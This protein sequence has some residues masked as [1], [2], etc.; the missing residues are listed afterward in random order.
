MGSK[1]DHLSDQ[2]TAE[3]KRAVWALVNR[4]KT[5][6]SKY[7]ALG[8]T[9]GHC[10]YCH[11][12]KV[13]LPMPKPLSLR[14]HYTDELKWSILNPIFELSENH[15]SMDAGERFP[16]KSTTFFHGQTLCPNEI[17]LQHKLATKGTPKPA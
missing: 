1:M 2:C 5:R 10:V 14:P 9:T 7:S 3:V 15:Q 11:A 6:G 17:F 13:G 12:S 8:R 16:K 4:I